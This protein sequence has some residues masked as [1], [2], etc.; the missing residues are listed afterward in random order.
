MP[1][2][3]RSRVQPEAL[4]NVRLSADVPSE[5]LG[6]GE[7]SKQAFKAAQNLGGLAESIAT[8]EFDK[9]NAIAVTDAVNR[10]V[11]FKNDLIYNKVNKTL[12]KDVLNGALQPHLDSFDQEINKIHGELNNPEQKFAYQQEAIKQKGELNKHVEAHTAAQSQKFANDTLIQSNELAGQTAIQNFTDPAAVKQAMADKV[13]AV[14]GLATLNGWSKEERDAK[15]IQT[16]SDTHLSVM[17]RMVDHDMLRAASAYFK[18]H[19]DEFWGND[20]RKAE[21][22]LESGTKEQQIMANAKNIAAQ[23]SS[24]ADAQDLIDKLPA[25]IQSRVRSEVSTRLQNQKRLEDQA[26]E[27]GFYEQMRSIYAGGQISPAARP[28][29]TPEQNR[30]L[31]KVREMR[32]RGQEPQAGGSEYYRLKTMALNPETRSAFMNESLPLYAADL[33][34]Q[35]LNELQVFQNGLRKKETKTT[36]ALDGFLSDQQVVNSVIIEAGLGKPDPKNE[37][38]NKLRTAIDLAVEQERNAAGGKPITNSRLRQIAKEKAADII[39]E[40][41]DEWYLPNKKKKAFDIGIEDIPA[42][43]KAQVKALLQRASKYPSDQ[44]VVDLYIKLKAKQNVQR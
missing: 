44:A 7:S 29:L 13:R 40:K 11:Q 24:M 9:A 32:D 10:T 8:A 18:E 26:P 19:K 38:Q 25:E 12:G 4:P 42:E 5:A 33:A 31:D 2:V 22:M 21:A 1:I 34:P 15:V 41:R 35:E 20:I 17:G 3:P 37:R 16:L 39:L 27:A 6:A 14:D 36:K 28:F 43:E 30:V 23:V